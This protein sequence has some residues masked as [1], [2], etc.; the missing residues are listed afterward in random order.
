MT[1]LLIVSFSFPPYHRVGARRWF[2]FGQVLSANGVQVHVIT[3]QKLS[4]FRSTEVDYGEIHVTRLPRK[5]PEEMIDFQADLVSKVR[6][7]AFEWMYRKS[8]R[9]NIYDY[10]L[11]WEGYF[12]KEIPAY[13]NKHGIKT[14]VITGGPFR[15]FSH[16][17]HLVEKGFNTILDYRDPWTTKSSMMS[18]TDNVTQAEQAFEQEAIDSATAILVASRDLRESMLEAVHLEVDE[19]NIH[20][21]E[22]GM[23]VADG[24]CT[25]KDLDFIRSKTNKTLKLVYF[26]G[27]HCDKDYFKDFLQATQRLSERGFDLSVDFYGNI[28]PFYNEEVR[29]MNSSVFSLKDRISNKAFLA[30]AETA[31]FFLYFKPLDKL[32]NS[33]GVKFYDYI[34]G[35][36][37]Q[38]IVA[39]AGDVKKLVD[40]TGIGISLDPKNFESDL[41]H[42]FNQRLEQKLFYSQDE[43]L[44]QKLSIAGQAEKLQN[45]LNRLERS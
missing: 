12:Q 1:K 27:I 35:R 39:P 3:A 23:D 21:L 19:R 7:K 32:Q 34:R 15:Y 36:R 29:K 42:V 8:R 45:L 24:F 16:N 4:R 38:L 26:G 2:K 14:V 13:M 18:L 40:E 20:V 11:N 9:G 5:F 31:D 41:T 30:V 25:V 33:F 22:N 28:N 37:L 17:R 6:Y 43:S 10:S 44:I